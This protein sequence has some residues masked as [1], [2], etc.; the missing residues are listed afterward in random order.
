MVKELG[1]PT[2]WREK[3]K[4]HGRDSKCG[5]KRILEMEEW[6]GQGCKSIDKSTLKSSHF[7]IYGLVIWIYSKL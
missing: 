6:E 7:I 1:V 5:K 4:M 3:M 2:E